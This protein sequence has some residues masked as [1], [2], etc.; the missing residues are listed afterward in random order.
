MISD[1]TCKRA[2][3]KR[4]WAEGLKKRNAQNGCCFRGIEFEIYMKNGENCVRSMKV[5]EQNGVYVT[6]QR[7]SVG[8]YEQTVDCVL[9]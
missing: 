7:F 1:D 5:L 3:K 8:Q 2:K 6:G 4:S 9:L